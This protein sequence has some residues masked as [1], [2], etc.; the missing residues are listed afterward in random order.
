MYTELKLSLNIFIQ[1]KTNN[2]IDN[3]CLNKNIR[4]YIASETGFMFLIDEDF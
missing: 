3:N 1:L 2:N 4:Y